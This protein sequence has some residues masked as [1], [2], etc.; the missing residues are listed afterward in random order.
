MVGVSDY[1]FQLIFNTI[2]GGLIVLALVRVWTV[3]AQLMTATRA[4]LD[5]LIVPELRPR[6]AGVWAE[7][8]ALLTAMAGATRP[9]P[10]T[11]LVLVLA[12]LLAISVTVSRATSPRLDDGTESAARAAD[13]GWTKYDFHTAWSFFL[14]SDLDGAP[15]GDLRY[16]VN[17]N[18]RTDFADLIQIYDW[19]Q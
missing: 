7:R 10:T 1:L 19:A 2:L 17:Q 8:T 9:V 5:A 6:L 11:I 14:N 13:S 18:G 16:D 15:Q 4:V 12:V 3:R